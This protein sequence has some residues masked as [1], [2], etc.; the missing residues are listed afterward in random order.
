M[1]RVSATIH[2]KMIHVLGIDENLKRP[3][4]LVLG[5][6]IEDDVVDGDVHRM[7]I[8]RRFYFVCGAFQRIHALRPR[9]LLRHADD[10]GRLSFFPCDR[11]GCTGCCFFFF[12]DDFEADY[13]YQCEYS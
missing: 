7:I 4:L 2:W 13:F 6:R 5:P 1:S 9:D 3:S 8:Q 11:C 12:L 10:L